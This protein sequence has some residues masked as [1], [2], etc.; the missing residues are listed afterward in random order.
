[1]RPGALSRNFGEYLIIKD[2]CYRVKS[3]VC[4]RGFFR[5]ERLTG[6]E[7]CSMSSFRSQYETTS[8]EIRGARPGGMLEL[9]ID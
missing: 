2:S 1:M 5:W 6:L 9:A 7:P 3:E 4:R 8:Y